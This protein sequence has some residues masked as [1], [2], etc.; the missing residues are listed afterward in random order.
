MTD[1]NETGPA[2][3]GSTERCANPGCGHTKR[4]H[5]GRRDHQAKGYRGDP[6]CHACETPCLYEPPAGVAPATDRATPS[7][8]A[9][10]RDEIVKALGLIK[11]VPPVAHRR[12]QADH[13]LAVLYREWPWLRA[14]A[15][16]TAPA[17]PATDRPALRDRIAAARQRLFGVRW[18][19]AEQFGTTL[20]EYTDAVLAVLPAS[21]DRATV[22]RQLADQQTQLAVIDDLAHRRDMAAARRQLVKELR[23]MAA[24]AGPE[25]PAA[26]QQPKEARP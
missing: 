15:E 3:Q 12:E 17:E 22:L 21:V 24:E 23:R 25:Q 26:V 7:R 5:S 13:V 1:Q 20:D 10:L 9:G 8:R 4:D 2:R 16:D 11:T 18:A 19:T 6:W 14:E